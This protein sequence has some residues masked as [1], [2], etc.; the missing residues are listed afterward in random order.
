MIVVKLRR[1]LKYPPPLIRHYGFLGRNLTVCGTSISN[2][3][4]VRGQ[5]IHRTVAIVILDKVL[6]FTQDSSKNPYRVDSTLLS[7]S[8]ASLSPFSKRL[9]PTISTKKL[10]R[11]ISLQVYSTPLPDAHRVVNQSNLPSDSDDDDDSGEEEEEEEKYRFSKGREMLRELM[12]QS[13]IGE[14][15]EAM[16]FEKT[17]EEED[18]EFEPLDEEEDDAMEVDMEEDSRCDEFGRRL[19]QLVRTAAPGGDKERLSSEELGAAIDQITNVLVAATHFFRSLLCES[20]VEA[21]RSLPNGE[22]LKA[23]RTVAELVVAG[24]GKEEV[25]NKT[26]REFLKRQQGEEEEKEKEESEERENE[27]AVEEVEESTRFQK[28]A[29]LSLLMRMSIEVRLQGGLPAFVSLRFVFSFESRRSET[30]ENWTLSLSQNFE[31]D[32]FHTSPSILRTFCTPS[33]NNFLPKLVEELFHRQASD[34]VEFNKIVREMKT[35][36]LSRFEIPSNQSRQSS[37]LIEA[38]TLLRSLLRNND[39]KF[40]RG[41]LKTPEKVLFPVLHDYYGLNFVETSSDGVLPIRKLSEQGRQQLKDRSDA[42]FGFIQ[43]LG[44]PTNDELDELSHEFWMYVLKP[45]I[46][47]KKLYHG[48]VYITREKISPLVLNSE[49]YTRAGLSKAQRG[50]STFPR[51]LLLYCENAILTLVVFR[52]FSE[53]RTTRSSGNVGETPLGKV[54]ARCSVPQARRITEG[55]PH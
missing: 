22:T 3:A 26:E 4:I 38:I 55:S 49:K 6:D 33:N 36:A 50:T 25:L 2:A 12:E 31:P 9:L 47:A 14:A 52:W 23:Y 39:K 29:P 5:G 48:E 30:D 34:S 11:L 44:I 46:G 45:E 15:F 8:F 20:Y 21:V 40:V 24:G 54:L 35:S 43:A 51:S 1:L 41:Q 28:N 32:G 53:R 16:D 19:F 18:V 42:V 17:E 37:P 27:D 13:G 10:K 7:S